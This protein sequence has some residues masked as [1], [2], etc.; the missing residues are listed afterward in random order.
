MVLPILVPCSVAK[1]EQGAGSLLSVYKIMQ[2]V[3]KLHDRRTDNRCD[4]GLRQGPSS[5]TEGS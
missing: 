1:D 3:N 4:K 5:D 2:S